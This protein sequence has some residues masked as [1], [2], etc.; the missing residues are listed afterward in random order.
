MDREALSPGAKKMRRYRHRQAN[1]LLVAH[2]GSVPLGLVEKLLEAGYLS[3]AEA[4]DR[5]ALGEALT[6]LG[7]D[8]LA[9]PEKLLPGNAQAPDSGVEPTNSNREPLERR[10]TIP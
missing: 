1:N 5:S 6:K 9:D 8:W 7:V 3:E 10:R 2:A 4:D